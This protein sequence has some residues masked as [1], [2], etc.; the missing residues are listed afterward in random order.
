MSFSSTQ[1][2]ELVNFA[3]KSN[4]CRRAL[5]SGILFARAAVSFGDNVSFNLEKLESAEFAARLI[6]EFYGQTPV[7]SRPSSGGRCVRVEF[8]SQSA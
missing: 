2:S 1:K 3:Y 6:K 5:L 8:K 4:C 7:I